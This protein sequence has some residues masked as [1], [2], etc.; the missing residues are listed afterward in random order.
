MASPWEPPPL[1]GARRQ[2]A[3]SRQ[4]WG[5]AGLLVRC[6]TTRTLRCYYRPRPP[7]PY[8]PP[9]PPERRPPRPPGRLPAL[10]RGFAALTVRERPPEGWPLRAWLAAWAS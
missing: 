2:P 6:A 9:P 5:R 7:P 8:P 4:K 10:S 3:R 1:A